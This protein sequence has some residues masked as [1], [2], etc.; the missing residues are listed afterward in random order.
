MRKL[1]LQLAEANV[2]MIALQKKETFWPYSR[3]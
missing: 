1:L 2:F 3:G